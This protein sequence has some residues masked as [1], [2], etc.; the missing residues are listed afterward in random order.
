MRPASIVQFERLFLGAL[1]LEVLV[2]VLAWQGEV[3]AAAKGYSQFAAVAPTLVGG[4]MAV[5]ILASLALW[6]F[7]A[8]RGSN[9][10]KWIVAVWFVVSTVL[11][12]LSLLHISF[13][14]PVVLGWL[15]Y[16]LRAWSVSYLF[17]P[18]AEAW[19]IRK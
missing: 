7:V 16:L 13:T 10:A 1:A 19:F 5:S 2:D 18:D 6:Y 14:L 9:I 3:A 12:A 17:K 11:L 15:A 8:R 4:I